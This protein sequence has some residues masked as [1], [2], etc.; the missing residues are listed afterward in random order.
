MNVGGVL[1]ISFDSLRT[2]V[3][4]EKEIKLKEILLSGLKTNKHE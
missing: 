2:V 4:S 3:S 1:L